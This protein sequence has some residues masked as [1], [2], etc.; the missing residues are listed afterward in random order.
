MFPIAVVSVAG[1]GGE[2]EAAK[3]CPTTW[4]DVEN[5]FVEAT[6]REKPVSPVAAIGLT[7]TLP[8][9]KREQRQ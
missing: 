1:V 4:L 7:P 5:V 3:S 6:V 2:Y 8:A 9:G